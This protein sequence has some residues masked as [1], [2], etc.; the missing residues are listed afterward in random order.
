MGSGI[1]C[2]YGA[3]AAIGE[4]RRYLVF[5]HACTTVPAVAQIRRFATATQ[6]DLDNRL[7]QL[8]WLAIEYVLSFA[9]LQAWY[10]LPD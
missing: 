2:A 7:Q 9:R 8:Q 4:S 3:I 5:M 6:F 1:H 10:A